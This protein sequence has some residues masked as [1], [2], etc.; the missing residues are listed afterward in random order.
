MIA[1]QADVEHR[2]QLDVTD[3]PDPVIETLLT[4]AQGHVE[5]ELGRPL[6]QA[7]HVERFDGLHAGWPRKTLFLKFLPIVSITTVVEGG[8]SLAGSDYLLYNDSP[9]EGRLIRVSAGNLIEWRTTKP[10]GIVITYQ[11]GYPAG[12]EPEDLVDVVAW[13][14]A[15]AFLVGTAIAA[16]GSVDGIKAEQI[17]THRTE[18]F[19][20]ADGLNSHLKIDDW[21]LGKIARYV[22]PGV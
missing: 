15:N 17:A 19:G 11:G 5:G 13:M 3:E 2:L 4:A 18:Y 10:Q 14:A 21:M 20:P 7:E 8:T 1:T 9:L 22:L 6:E 12:E 16:G